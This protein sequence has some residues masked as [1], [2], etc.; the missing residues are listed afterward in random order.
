MKTPKP[1]LLAAA[2]AG[3]LLLLS[4]AP[5]QAQQ[6][7]NGSVHQYWTLP[8]TAWNVDTWIYP[9]VLAN[10]MFFAQTLWFQNH[11]GCAGNPDPNCRDVLYLGI[12]Q[13]AGAGTRSAR[14]S[15][16]NT[17]TAR[18][19]HC[20][21][22]GGEGTGMTCFRG[23]P[24]VENHA[25]TL[26][27]WRLENDGAGQWWGAWIIDTATGV[28]THLGDIRA[29]AGTGELQSAVSFNE[30]FGPAVPC[31]QLPHSSVA[32]G[33]PTINGGAAT[34]AFGPTNVGSCS[35]GSVTPTI[36]GTSILDVGQGC[37]AGGAGAGGLMMAP[38]AALFLRR[39]R[40]RA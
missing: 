5:A 13:G 4:S 38:M 6:H 12:Q 28:E 16:W 7:Q 31:D 10:S 22:F 40:R 15:L 14:F 37:N 11:P 18:G 23:Y 32:F 30:Y 9:G 39:R 19:P 25:Y 35:N 36:Y 26:R 17:T 8:G 3:A 27:V 24:F 33:A 2:L 1:S 21:P 20:E 34:A 29:T